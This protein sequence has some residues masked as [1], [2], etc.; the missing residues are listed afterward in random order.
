MDICGLD[1]ITLVRNVV[2]NA[3]PHESRKCPRWSA[4]RETLAI[5]RNSAYALCQHF[6][7]DPDEYVGSDSE[8]EEEEHSDWQANQLILV[9]AYIGYFKGNGRAPSIRE[10][11]DITGLSFDTVSAHIGEFEVS[12]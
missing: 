2:A 11:A 12:Q 5:G 1:S 8:E 10:L 6:G 7:F 9:Q 4:V 3:R